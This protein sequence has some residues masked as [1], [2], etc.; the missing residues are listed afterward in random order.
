MP[1]IPLYGHDELKSRL[2]EA[3]ARGSMPGSLLLQGTRGVGKQRLALWL[4][5]LLQ[6]ESGDRAP[7]DACKGCR[8]ARELTHPDVHWFFPRPRLRDSDD[9]GAVKEDYAEAIA[10]RVVDH[11]LYAAP[12]GL[13]AIFIGT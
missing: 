1:I 2:R 9:A 7:C 8:F 13:E 6:C 3:V 5:Q 11:G 10:E 4:A 12:S